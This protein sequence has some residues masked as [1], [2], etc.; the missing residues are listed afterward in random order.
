MFVLASL[1]S[2]RTHRHRKE[3]NSTVKFRFDNITFRYIHDSYDGTSRGRSGYPECQDSRT[4]AGAGPY[5]K[6]PQRDGEK[7]RENFTGS[8][9]GK[10]RQ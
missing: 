10:T 2:I 4:E 5:G 9:K 1:H 3:E 8:F 7:E 6:Y